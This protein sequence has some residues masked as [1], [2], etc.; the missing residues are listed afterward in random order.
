MARACSKFLLDSAGSIHD[1]KCLMTAIMVKCA[2]W[3]RSFTDN[4]SLN[5]HLQ[6]R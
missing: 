2:L 4:V 3:A 5:P 6:I 1:N